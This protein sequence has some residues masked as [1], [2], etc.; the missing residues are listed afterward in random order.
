VDGD[1]VA[2]PSA[3]SCEPTK[4]KLEREPLDIAISR[5]DEV[6]R[7]ILHATNARE[8]KLFIGGADNF[9]YQIDPTYKANRTDKPRPQHL[10]DVREFLV[11]EWKAHISDGIET[12]DHLGI[13]QSADNGPDET[14]ICT[15]DK[16]LLQVPGRHYNFQKDI[17]SYVTPLQGWASFYTQLIMGDRSDNIQGYD[18]KMRV[19]VP[20]FLQS[21]VSDLHESCSNPWE[22]FQLVQGIYELGEERLVSNARLLYILRHEQDQWEIPLEVSV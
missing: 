22:M 8:Y 5:A 12:D 19:S 3:A 9:R 18:G 17:W 11:T 7:R 6:M 1:L 20:K 10:Q 15:Y 21:Y 2:Y 16:D 13:E 14:V 4:A